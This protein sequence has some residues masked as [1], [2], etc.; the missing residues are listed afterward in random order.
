MI[1]TIVNL[2]NETDFLK[3]YINTQI[4]HHMLPSKYVKYITS[5]NVSV[6]DQEAIMRDIDWDFAN[7]FKTIRNLYPE[8]GYTISVNTTNEKPQINKQ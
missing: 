8:G 1:E 4:Y 7:Q 5:D 6:P 3:K 2:S